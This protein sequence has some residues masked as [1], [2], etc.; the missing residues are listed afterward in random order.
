MVEADK[1]CK[2][3]ENSVTAREPMEPQK[4]KVIISSNTDDF[5][6]NVLKVSLAKYFEKFVG[7]EMDEE[8]LEEIKKDITKFIGRLVRT[9]VSVEIID[10]S[11]EEGPKVQVHFELMHELK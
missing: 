6:H 10:D 2:I 3:T 4:T 7:H 5:T 11:N 9:G 8:G 1:K